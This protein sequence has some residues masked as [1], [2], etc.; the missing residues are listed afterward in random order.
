MFNEFQMKVKKFSYAGGGPNL[1]ISLL[2][3]FH[4]SGRGN[5]IETKVNRGNISWH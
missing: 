1:A 4:L 3:D 5:S 2:E